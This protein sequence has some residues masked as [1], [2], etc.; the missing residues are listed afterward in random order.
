[1]KSQSKIDQ[2][3]MDIALRVAEESY[4]VRKKVGSIL[5]HNNSNIISYGYNGTQA[6]AD[7]CCEIEQ[8]GL[9][10]TK[11]TVNHAEHNAIRKL[12]VGEAKGCTLY[13]TLLPCLACSK[14][15]IESQI[16]RVVFLEDYKC[17]LGYNNLIVHN[18]KVDKYKDYTIKFGH[19]ILDNIEPLSYKNKITGK[20][21]FCK[22]YTTWYNLIKRVYSHKYHSVNPTYKDCTLCDDWHYF[23]KFKTWMMKQNWK[24]MQLDK[25]ILFPNNKHYSPERCTFV[26]QQINKFLTD[27]GRNR[28]NYMIGVNF[29]N[30]KFI[31]QININSKRTYL[32][33]FTTELDAHIAWKTKKIELYNDLIN[34]PKN[35]EIKNGL[36]RHRDL[37]SHDGWYKPPDR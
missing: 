11:D 29:K 10:I 17:K 22:Y 13:C 23:S 30:N 33:S 1:M 12:K 7:N 35:N 3:H 2:L 4:C 37:L 27:S 8:D 9:L 32:G 14:E 19:G 5:V 28:G 18:I 26:T 6:G 36:I 16:S 20:R 34:D 25:D 15:I 21:V 31:S 24:G